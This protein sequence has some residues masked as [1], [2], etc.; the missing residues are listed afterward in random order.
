MNYILISLLVVDIVGGVELVIYSHVP[1][2]FLVVILQLDAISVMLAA[3]VCVVIVGLLITLLNTMLSL[4]RLLA[5]S[6]TR[7]LNDRPRLPRK[8][9]GNRSTES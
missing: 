4:F 3:C 1:I 6:F 5:R 9:I 8:L 7:S 2:M